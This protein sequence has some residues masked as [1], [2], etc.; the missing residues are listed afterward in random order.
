[1]VFVDRSLLERVGTFKARF[2]RWAPVLAKPAT[3]DLH[4]SSHESTYATGTYSV[5]VTSGGAEKVTV[6]LKGAKP[7][8]E[9]VVKINRPGY[10]DY[11][12]VGSITA[13]GRGSG[14]VTGTTSFPSGAQRRICSSRKTSIVF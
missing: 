5:G 9:Y 10:D 6:S 8:T 11:T 3:G 7:D 13:S 1:M 4:S 2:P 14:R 12:T